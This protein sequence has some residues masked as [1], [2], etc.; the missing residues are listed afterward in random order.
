MSSPTVVWSQP[1]TASTVDAPE[2]PERAGDDQQRVQLAPPHAPDQE[3]AEVLH[4]LQRGE[5][6]GRQPHL[7]DAPVLDRAAVRDPHD[8][9]GG[10]DQVGIVEQRL[11]HAQQRFRL[12][13][14]VGVDGAHVGVAGRVHAGVQRVGL[15]A[16]LLVDHEQLP[17]PRRAVGA[18]DRRV[19]DRPAQRA[20]RRDQVE[21][22][23]ELL[24]RR[25]LG[26][27]VDDDHLE[28]RV[29]QL[30]QRVDALDDP[31]LLVVAGQQD[32][33]RRRERGGERL[34][35]RRV[36]ERV[37]VARDRP[38]RERGE[39]DVEQVQDGE[40]ADDDDAEDLDGVAD[41]AGS[42]S[43]SAA[44]SAR[45][46]L[47]PSPPPSCIARGGSIAASACAAACAGS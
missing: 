7:G 17:V 15:A 47:A 31:G 12:D 8:P 41:H 25:V 3:R 33:D 46:A 36:L 24:H 20:R 43:A 35:D 18:V 13:D 30:Q 2:E 28:L 45:C 44:A 9:A 10:D 11:G 26:T 6:A 34:V 29:P 5:P 14:G 37:Q 38:P 27:V 23:L 4:H 22:L 42:S 32:R 21:R 40:V 1:P 19:R 16:V 39:H